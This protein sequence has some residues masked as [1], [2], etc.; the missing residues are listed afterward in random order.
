MAHPTSQ[1]LHW[2]GPIHAAEGA[3][4]IDWLCVAPRVGGGGAPIQ[5]LPQL[6]LVRCCRDYVH[7]DTG[8]LTS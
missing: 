1:P 7:G 2:Q 3:L 6:M 4:G 5:L 8:T